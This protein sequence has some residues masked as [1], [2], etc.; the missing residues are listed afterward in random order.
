MS[1]SAPVTEVEA[2]PR[3]TVVLLGNSN[4]QMQ[5]VDPDTGLQ[6]SV[7][8][9]H[10]DRSVT[11]VEIRPELLDPEFV[12]HTLSTDNDRFLSMI[13]RTLPDEHRIFALALNELE[14]HVDV[15]HGRGRPD[16][17]TSSDPD[18]AEAIGRHF[19]CPVGEPTMLLVSVGR[20][21]LHQQHVG[22]GAQPAAFNYLALT[23][24]SA[25]PATSDTTLAGEIATA[26]GGL[27]RKQA[28]SVA[29]TVGTNTTTLSATFT[30]NGADVL[31]VTV[32][33]LGV[34]NAAAAGTLGYSTLL[35]A[36]ATLT[37]SGDNVTI[38]ETLTAG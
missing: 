34:F 7:P 5:V 26:G 38:T 12:E 1:V 11:R 16:W 4:P 13:A 36:T 25:A 14:Q 17:V 28:T 31:A 18:L 6:R 9:E 20:D 27:V 35:N 23:A 33:K 24:N 32:A 8:A 21:G 15:H 3:N 10:L 37:V 19:A 29:H 30:A 2:A 22:L